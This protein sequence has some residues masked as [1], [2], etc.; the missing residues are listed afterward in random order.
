MVKHNNALVKNHF[1]K[2]WER[3]VKTWFSQPA[4]KIKRKL[5]RQARAAK[6]FPRPTELLRPLVHCQTNRYNTKIRLGRGF[7]L[8]ELKEAKLDPVQAKS[9]G[10]AVDFRRKNR[11]LETKRTNV[12]RLQLYKAK[13]VVF[14]RRKSVTISK[15]GKEPVKKSKRAS[16]HLKLFNVGTPK[17][18]EKA[19]QLNTQ[20]PYVF[21]FNHELPREIT[22]QERASSAYL[23][24]R[25]A[26]GQANKVGDKIRKE[27]KAALGIIAANAKAG[28][29]GKG[30]AKEEDAGDDDE[31]GKGKGKGK[32][33]GA[34][35][36]AKG[37][38]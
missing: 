16:K 35:A 28:T 18:E 4:R 33:A 1:R 27:R 36:G 11:S 23:T 14:P 9:V 19:Q 34:G 31:E 13:V 2:D 3:H 12:Q 17:D 5:K 21:P 10:I 6:I 30:K 25:K 8:D 22:E 32:G 20:F 38:K 37:K 24:L 26:R 15:K 7:S 29:A